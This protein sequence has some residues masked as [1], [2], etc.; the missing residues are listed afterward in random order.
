MTNAARCGDCAHFRNA[1]GFLEQALPGL[2]SLSSG[3]ASVRAD[4]GLCLHHDRLVAVGDRCAA[5]AARVE[6]Q[7]TARG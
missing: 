5:F 3:D 1:A 4:D 7:A 6:A 2:A